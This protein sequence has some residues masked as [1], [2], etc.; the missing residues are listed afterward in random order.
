MKSPS[1]SFGA[2][3]PFIYLLFFSRNAKLIFTFSYFRI[4]SSISRIKTLG[5]VFSFESACISYI[6]DKHFVMRTHIFCKW[7]ERIL[8]RSYPSRPSDVYL[9]TQYLQLVQTFLQW[10]VKSNIIRHL[11]FCIMELNPFTSLELQL[12]TYHFLFSTINVTFES[13]RKNIWRWWTYIILKKIE[14]CLSEW[15]NDFSIVQYANSNCSICC[16]HIKFDRNIPRNNNY[17]E[18]KIQTKNNGEI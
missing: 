5:S 1:Y 8:G 18:M 9:E 13:P 16:K 10:L 7:Y 17:I 4:S 2:Y 12:F 14:L 15:K 11:I 6:T 3:K